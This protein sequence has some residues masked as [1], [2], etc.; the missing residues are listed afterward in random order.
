MSSQ[1]LGADS[2]SAFYEG[3][4]S[5]EVLQSYAVSGKGSG[6]R[7]QEGWSFRRIAKAIGTAALYASG[8]AL[9]GTQQAMVEFSGQSGSG[10]A[11]FLVGTT[12]L[13]LPSYVGGEHL[14]W[15]EGQ[16]TLAPP[17]YGEDQATREESI[18]AEETTTFDATSPRENPSTD[19]MQVGEDG[20]TYINPNVLTPAETIPALRGTVPPA[21]PATVTID[22]EGKLECGFS[23]EPDSSMSFLETGT[24][25]SLN[26]EDIQRMITI[27]QGADAEELKINALVE[28]VGGDECRS[29]FLKES[30]KAGNFILRK[31]ARGQA[32][33][34]IESIADAWK[35]IMNEAIKTVKL[36][37]ILARLQADT[38]G[39]VNYVPTASVQYLGTQVVIDLEP[40][41]KKAMKDKKSGDKNIA[42]AYF[43][44]VAKKHGAAE[45]AWMRKLGNDQGLFTPTYPLGCAGE[46]FISSWKHRERGCNY[47]LCVGD[48]NYC[49]IATFYQGQTIESR[50]GEQGLYGRYVDAVLASGHYEQDALRAAYVPE[51]CLN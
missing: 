49:Q 32:L 8:Q 18:I 48:Y 20:L 7:S 37:Q 36:R 27:L 45:V 14:S 33:P 13:T 29:D 35:T 2:M 5:S 39:I 25:V 3:E 11:P 31:R 46:Y 4:T 38:P 22:E 19:P 40:G 44:L 21:A 43:T 34:V 26:G 23:D 41:I 16:E 9:S 12:V 30:L 6:G 47:G 10:V 17:A 1:S 24:M 51:I 15:E 50:F 42:N 28:W